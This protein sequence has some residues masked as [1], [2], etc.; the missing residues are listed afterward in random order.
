[1]GQGSG[2]VWLQNRVLRSSSN[3]VFSLS[4][5]QFGSSVSRP[6]LRHSLPPPEQGHCSGTREVQRFLLQPLRRAKE[7][8][9]SAPHFGSEAPEQVRKS[10]TLQD[11]IAQVGHFFDGKRGI[12]GI[13]T[14][15]GCL[16]SHSD[17]PASSEVPPLCRSRGPFSVH[18]LNLRPCHGAQGIHK[19]HGG[20]HGHSPFSRS[21]HVTLLRRSPHKGSVFSGLRVKRPHYPGFSFAPGLVDQLGQVL[22]R[23][24]PSDLLSGNDPGHF[25]GSGLASSVQGPSASAGSPNAPPSSPTNHSV[26]HEDPGK[27]GCSNRSGSF[28][29][30]PSS[31]LATGF[32]GQLGQESPISRPSLPAVPAGQTISRM[33]DPGS[34]S[35][36]G[37]VLSPDP[38]VSGNY[39]RQSPRLGGGVSS[40]LCPGPLDSSGIETPHQHPGDSCYQTCPES[41]SRPARGSPN[42]SPIGQRHGGGLH[43]PPG[44]YPQ[45]GGNAG[46]LSHPS[47]GRNQPF[48]H[49][50]GAHSRS[51][52][53]GGGL[54]EPPGPCLGG[55]GTPPRG[56][57][58]NLSSLGDPGRGSDGVQIERQ[59]PQIH[60]AF[61]GSPGH[62]SRRADFSVASV[63]T[64][65]RVS[66]PSLTAEG[67]PK[68]QDGGSSGHSGR[69][70]LATPRLVRGTRSAR[71][72]RSLAVTRP[73]RPASP[74]SDLPPELRGPTFNGVAVETW[75]L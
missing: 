22:S 8:R 32:A 57:S 3:S 56:F 9:K 18:G 21:R 15:Q 74:R 41:L 67:D 13:D 62:R 14:H 65:I 52:E 17:I 69:P 72:R 2:V 48:H 26:R 46:S 40:P 35:S 34:I 50:C 43:Q 20:G 53:L 44:G 11:G 30:T 4:S 71:S 12:L 60:C 27:D 63:S 23:S 38:L 6:P 54:S 7:G 25:K 19:G 68:D 42:T 10:T 45:Q 39:R 16:S 61:S 75:I 51:R 59:G 66:S 70:R 47:L 31:P 58:S 29:S 73:P 36:P 64:P 1:M 33:V 24:C 49:F 5:P 28:R 37:E 55:V